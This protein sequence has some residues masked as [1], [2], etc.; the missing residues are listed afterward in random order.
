MICVDDLRKWKIK[1]KAEL[2]SPCFLVSLLLLQIIISIL[3]VTVSPCPI[4]RTASPSSFLGVKNEKEAGED[5]FLSFQ[6]PISPSF[7]GGTSQNFTLL[8]GHHMWHTISKS[9]SFPWKW[10]LSDFSSKKALLLHCSLDLNM[11]SLPDCFFENVYLL[12]CPHG[13]LLWLLP[14]HGVLR[15]SKD[16]WTFLN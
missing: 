3:T 6:R 13:C 12:S 2:H 7:W 9:V 11:F 10:C 4:F 15:N 5:F 8:S 1:M 16:S 14:T